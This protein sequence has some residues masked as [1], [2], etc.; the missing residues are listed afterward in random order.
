MEKCSPVNVL[1]SDSAASLPP[2]FPGGGQPGRIAVGNA[3]NGE[4]V[5]RL[6]GV[7]LSGEWTPQKRCFAPCRAATMARRDGG[8]VGVRGLLLSGGVAGPRRER[9][10]LPGQGDPLLAPRLDP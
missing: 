7:S 9:A 5:A 1:G 2:G 10:V 3:R 8:R 4:T 6:R